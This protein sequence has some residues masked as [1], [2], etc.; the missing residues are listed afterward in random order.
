M[1]TVGFLI[2]VYLSEEMV[3]LCPVSTSL[4]I[5]LLYAAF[6]MVSYVSSIPSFFKIFIMKAG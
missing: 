6:L 3:S 2:S 4:A 1:K 5:G